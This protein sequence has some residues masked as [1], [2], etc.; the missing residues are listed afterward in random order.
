[1]STIP[2]YRRL[3]ATAALVVLALVA[4][5][6]I[7]RERVAAA[8]SA[9]ATCYL[10]FSAGLDQGPDA[11]LTLA[12]VLTLNVEDDGV[13]SGT[14]SRDDGP[15]VIAGDGGIDAATL[16]VTGQLGRRSLNIAVDLGDGRYVF[17]E[18]TVVTDRGGCAGTTELTPGSLLGGGVA[19][20]P[21][22]GDRGD[23]GIFDTETGS[24]SV[25][26]CTTTRS[27][28]VEVTVC[29]TIKRST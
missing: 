15:L 28:N 2:R 7:P 8:G 14:L 17:G 20:G 18:G 24:G 5:H 12:G 26:T 19:E 3:S 29:V 22:L 1:M 21:R 6:T 16:P 13:F 9:P 11:P 27:G 10:G 25:T 4:L 23:W